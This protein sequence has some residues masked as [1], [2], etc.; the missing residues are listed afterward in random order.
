MYYLSVFFFKITSTRPILKMKRP[1]VGTHGLKKYV[2]T[3]IRL[4]LG[5]G[6]TCGGKRRGVD[7]SRLR[8]GI[9]ESYT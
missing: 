8:Y 7:S 4:L 1:W 9:Y 2:Q 5:G 3:G 6:Q